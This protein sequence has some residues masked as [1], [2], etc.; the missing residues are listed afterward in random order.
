MFAAADRGEIPES[1]PHE[2]AH[3]TKN[4]SAL[5][6]H[7]GG[8]KKKKHK[9]ESAD[10]ANVVARLLLE[11]FFKLAQGPS[12]MGTP[13]LRPELYPDP[14]ESGGFAGIIAEDAKRR[15]HWPI[16]PWQSPP[17]TNPAIP[18]PAPPPPL[19]P[20]SPIFTGGVGGKDVP[21]HPMPRG[22]P[23]PA[24]MQMLRKGGCDE[25]ATSRPVLLKEAREFTSK[26]QQRWA[27]A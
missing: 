10:A 9:K 13:P 11:S 16:R 20:G 7:V 26:R 2:W 5:P 8:K 23:S 12:P 21:V 14:A 4:I 3:H 25:H 27:F 24:L 15:G 22:G 18:P 17:S 6:E 1:M 19:P